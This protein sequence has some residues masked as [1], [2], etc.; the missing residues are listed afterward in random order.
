VNT[1]GESD[2][3]LAEAVQRPL[4]GAQWVAIT[5]RLPEPNASVALIHIDRWENVGDV[6]WNRNVHA[7]GYLADWGGLPGYW[8]VRGERALSLDAFTHWM[9]LPPPPAASGLSLE[10]PEPK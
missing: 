2:R 6:D 5:E 9:P 8:S 1:S 7:C 10:A 3:A 4:D